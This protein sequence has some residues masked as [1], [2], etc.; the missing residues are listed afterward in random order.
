MAPKFPDW[1]ENYPEM[2]RRLQH[3]KKRTSGK[4]G[5]NST[6]KK[7]KIEDDDADDA[8]IRRLEAMLGLKGSGKSRNSKL[9]RG[10]ARIGLPSG[11][12]KLLD[13]IDNMEKRIDGG[14][15]VPDAVAA[16]AIASSDDEAPE[17]VKRTASDSEPE[18]AEVEEDVE[19][20]ESHSDESQEDGAGSE[21]DESERETESKLDGGEPV[22]AKLPPPSAGAWIP[23]SRRGLLKGVLSGR[24]LSAPQPAAPVPEK[25]KQ[26][27]YG[28]DLPSVDPSA[29]LSLLQL[30]DSNPEY[31]KIK[32]RVQVGATVFQAVRCLRS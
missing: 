11:L 25:P 12:D 7:H 2:L 26:N 22:A 17:L 4:A 18:S 27:L 31:A 13:D 15:A 21:E 29:K 28:K 3:H 1:A 6:A 23:P 9:A 32:R 20:S 16:A 24:P 8:E 19:E 10:L 5:G 14:S 30:N